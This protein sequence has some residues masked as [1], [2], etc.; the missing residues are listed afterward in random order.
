MAVSKKK[1][2]EIAERRSK[3]IKLYIQRWTQSEIASHL[4]VSQVC[5]HKD[6]KAIQK[7]WRDANLEQLSEMKFEE[8]QRIDLLE[9]QAWE[10][11]MESKTY[12]KVVQVGG[13]KDKRPS[14][15]RQTNETGG[16]DPRFLQIIS[17]CIEQRAKLLGLN[18]P[19]LLKVD[20]EGNYNKFSAFLEQVLN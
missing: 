10:G 1:K 18:E 8:L 3:V 16:G 12:T 6:I 14:Q 19:E 15:V 2:L 17:R 13:R 20:H 4:G 5:I 9:R 11:Y 7:E